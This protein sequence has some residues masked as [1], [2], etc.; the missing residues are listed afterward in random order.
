AVLEVD[1][2]VL[3][4]QSSR[5]AAKVPLP[6]RSLAPLRVLDHAPVRLRA[7]DLDRLV[8]VARREDQLHEALAQLRPELPV[9]LAV[10]DDHTAVGAGRIAGESALI[11]L[12]R[13]FADADTARIVVLDDCAGRQLELAQQAAARV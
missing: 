9:D 10:E 4:E 2:G 5:D 7:D 13:R 6:R 11:G 12:E 1:V 3:Y 8:L